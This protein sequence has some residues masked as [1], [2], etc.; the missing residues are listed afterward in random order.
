MEF[1]DGTNQ[2][3]LSDFSHS[4]DCDALFQQSR[5]EAVSVYREKNVNFT[6]LFMVLVH[7]IL[8]M[9]DQCFK[10]VVQNVLIEP[11]DWSCSNCGVNCLMIIKSM[12]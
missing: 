10:I 6:C 11:L 12:F 7:Y 5:I 8:I 3:L 2:D 4:C 9:S 1:R